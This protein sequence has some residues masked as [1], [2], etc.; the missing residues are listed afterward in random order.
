MLAPFFHYLTPSFI[1]SSAN[2]LPVFFYNYTATV[3]APVA[4][5]MTEEAIEAIVVRVTGTDFLY[6]VSF[7]FFYCRL[8]IFDDLARL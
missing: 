2:F 8:F 1:I 5:I 7:H 3:A 6:A 4:P